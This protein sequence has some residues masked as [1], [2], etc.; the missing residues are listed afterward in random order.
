MSTELPPNERPAEAAS[1][2]T[3]SSGAMWG[4]LALIAVGVIFLLVN[5]GVFSLGRL[6]DNWWALFIL[7]PIFGILGNLF[8]A[9]QRQDG[10]F[11][12]AVASQLVGLA[13]LTLI[14]FVFL[15]GLNWGKIW[16]AFLI[17]AGIGALS[18]VWAGQG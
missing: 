18:R 5:I 2:G 7:L 8:R 3:M 16:P 12:S 6:P 1:G 13:I 15:F 17:I 14:M 11:R 4:G 10:S 9:Y